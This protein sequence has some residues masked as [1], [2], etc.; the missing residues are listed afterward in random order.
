M[1]EHVK[2]YLKQGY[3]IRLFTTCVWCNGRYICS[4]VSA[5]NNLPASTMGTLAQWVLDQLPKQEFTKNAIGT[6]ESVKATLWHKN[7]ASIATI[8]YIN[9]HQDVEPV[10]EVQVPEHILQLE[11]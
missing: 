9:E 1:K 11:L 4:Q 5:I 2:Q 7:G 3:T 6:Y 10:V 8:G